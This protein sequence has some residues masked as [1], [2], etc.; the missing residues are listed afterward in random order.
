M[1]ISFLGQG[2][3][4]KSVNAV[5]NHLVNFLSLTGFDSF[6]GISAFAS[7]SGVYGLS[8]FLNAAKNNFK[9]LNLIVGVDLEG[10]S[11]EALEE[12]LAL[13][14][15][16]YVFYQQEQPVFH[17]KIF[18]IEGA[19]ETKIIIGS[20]NLTR[21]GLFTNVESSMLIEFDLNDKEGLALLSELKSYY[22]SLFDFSDPNLLKV[23]TSIIAELFSKGI[24]PDETTRRSNYAKRLTGT[25][26][27]S[28]ASTSTVIIQKRATAKVPSTF[29]SKP[30]T[31][32]SS[33]AT[34]SPQTIAQSTITPPIINQAQQ[35]V[36]VWQKLSLSRSDAQSVPTGTNGTGN[37]K[38]SQ[39]SFRLNGVL[40]NHNTYFRNQVFQHLGWARTKPTST[41]YE[42][43]ICNFDVT[44]LGTSHGLQPIKLSY[45]PIRISNQANTPS[46]LHWG[47]V[48]MS[49]LQQTN[50]TGRTLN[51]YQL[52]NQSFSIEIV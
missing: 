19:K 3:E 6:T 44:I 24:I 2:F 26:S 33:N 52:G 17:P 10:T 20:S 38:L 21:G 45:D 37:L 25:S 34:T 13:N 7:E 18:L 46:W 23:S 1:K 14:I 9:H 30:K 39:A 16:S 49:I 31:A 50:V 40:I 36:L 47:N 15:N 4:D 43:T 27:G 42:E 48:L 5:G 22:Q 11:K 8:G 41:T 12:I 51:L 32:G 29:P 28:S 35:R